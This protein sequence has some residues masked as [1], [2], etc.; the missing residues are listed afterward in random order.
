[1]VGLVSTLLILAMLVVILIKVHTRRHPQYESTHTG[2]N[3]GNTPASSDTRNNTVSL[4]KINSHPGGAF[5]SLS[6]SGS[7]D[8][9]L[10]PLR[11]STSSRIGMGLFFEIFSHEAILCKGKRIGIKSILWQKCTDRYQ[12]SH[13]TKIGVKTFVWD[14]SEAD[15]QQARLTK[16]LHNPFSSY[17][18]VFCACIKPISILWCISLCK[19]LAYCKYFSVLLDAQCSYLTCLE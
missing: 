3:V 16:F 10:I 17:L 7:D 2:V 6:P 13:K 4:Q 5:G 15:G 9:D 18:D 1:M 11:S 12:K 19:I 14:F 8:P